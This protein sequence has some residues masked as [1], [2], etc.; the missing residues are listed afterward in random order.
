MK[1]GE[2]VNDYFACA[3]AIVNKL[4]VN[5]AKIDDVNIVEKILRSMTP[6]FNYVVCFIEELLQLTNYKAVF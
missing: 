3:L 4:Q 6:R 5:K 1:D 2:S